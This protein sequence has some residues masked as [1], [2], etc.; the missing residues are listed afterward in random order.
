MSKQH[1]QVIQEEVEYYSPEDTHGKMAVYTVAYFLFLAIL[2]VVTR[3]LN[4]GMPGLVFSMI[5]AGIALALLILGVKFGYQAARR[6]I[7]NSGLGGLTGRELAQMAVGY[8]PYQVEEQDDDDAVENAAPVMPSQVIEEHPLKLS[9]RYQPSIKSFLSATVAIIGMRRSGKS[10]LLAVLA[11]EL[12]KY[13]LSFVLFDTEAEYS[14]LVNSAY[15]QRPVLAGNATEIPEE[16]R[17]HYVQ[18]D[19]E[20]AYAFGQAIMQSGLQVVVDLRSYDNDEDAALVMSEII[21]G[22]EDW[23]QAR[24]TGTRVP[25]T[26]FLDESQKWFPQS[27]EDKVVSSETQVTLDQAFYGT[28]VARGGKRGFGL[29][30]AAQRYSQLNK[31]LLQ[32]QH[33]FLFFQN[34][35]I[36]IARYAKLGIPAEGTASLVQGECYCFGP[37]VIGMRVMMRERTSPHG[38]HTPGLESLNKHT[39]QL[40]PVTEVLSKSYS[41]AT[42]VLAPPII[43]SQP[44]RKI[45]PERIQ[46]GKDVSLSMQQFEVAVRLRKNGMST[47]YRDLMTTFELSEHHAKVLNARIRTEL[48]LGP[49][50]VSE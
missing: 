15:L 9:E 47:G 34:E 22:I 40:A 13:G 1:Q 12:A 45:E 2:I 35:E 5:G 31:K 39:L 8:N 6:K 28:V 32:S 50:Q 18:L 49:E 19:T 46:L 41:K 38:G 16:H 3:K 11:E 30:V 27:K 7:A 26:V 20:G 37:S 44:A 17:S 21:D 25:M 29:V 14:E 23:Q 10:N 42:N 33:K 48:G 24:P 4:M 43:E 36:D